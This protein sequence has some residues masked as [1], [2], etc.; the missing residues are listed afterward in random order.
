ML[1]EDNRLNNDIISNNI[2]LLQIMCKLDVEL[3]F[4]N[5]YS[6]KKKAIDEGKIW[7]EKL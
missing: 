1:N 7:L 2:Y 6:S 3:H 5:V 4:E